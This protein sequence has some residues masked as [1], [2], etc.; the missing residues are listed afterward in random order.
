MKKLIL[1]ISML[2]GG[3]LNAQTYPLIENFDGVATSGSPATGALPSGWTA[4]VGSTF[5]VYGLENL[6]PHGQSPSNACAVEMTSTHTTDTL[7][8]PDIG[9]ITANLKVSISYRFMNKSG[10]PAT[11]YQ[12]VTGDK[13]TIDAYLGNSW[14]TLLTLDATTNPTPLSSYTTYTYNCT[15][16]NLLI[17]GGITTIKVRMVVDGAGTGDWYLDVDDF[18]VADNIVGIENHESNPIGLS[19]YPN[20]AHNN[21]TVSLKN[22]TGTNPVELKL[23][24]NMGQLVK[25]VDTKNVLNNQFNINTTDLARGMYIVEVKSGNEVSKTKVVIE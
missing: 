15:S 3:L 4:G 14:T 9:P 10:Y 12:L 18:K 21:F 1:S 2:V 13:V 11:G 8:T 23:F 17:F 25:T 19:T 16:C 22:Y 20:P 6:A 7:F 24:N 5:K